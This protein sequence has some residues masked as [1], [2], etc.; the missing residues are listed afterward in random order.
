[1]EVTDLAVD[2]EDLMREA[3]VGRGPALGAT[4]R[5][6]R[7]VVVED[8]SRNERALLLQLARDWAMQAG[9]G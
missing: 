1:M 5:R 2:G 6:L 8:P 7:D 9:E 3:G 4:L